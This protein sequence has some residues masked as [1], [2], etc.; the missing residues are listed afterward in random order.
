MIRIEFQTIANMNSL[1]VTGLTFPLAVRDVSKFETLNPDI[2]VNVGNDVGYVPLY[3][4]KQRNRR[5]HINLFFLEGTDDQGNELQHYV[6]I[7][8]MCRLVADRTKYTTLTYVCNSCFHPF[9]DKEVLQRHIPYC[10]RHRPQ[11]VRYPDPEDEKQCTI[12]FKNTRAQFRLPFYL[13]RDFESFL[14]PADNDDDVDAVKATKLVDI[15]NLCGFACY[16]VTEHEKYQT[17]PTVYSGPNVMDKFYE[18]VMEES[19]VIGRVVTNELGMEPLIDDELERHAA[20]TTCEVCRKPFTE[21]NHKVRH[22]DHI[23]GK[24]VGTTCNRC[25]LGLRYPNRKH[26]A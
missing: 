25:N 26:K 19:L 24:Y 5:H 11:D 20:A 21:D 23:T 13:V 9:C 6:W 18:H 12:K 22:H 7:K 3:I 8:N 10:E 1:N 15:H 17:E 16:R 14:T 2:S 4:S